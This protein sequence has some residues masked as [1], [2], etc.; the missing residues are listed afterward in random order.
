VFYSLLNQTFKSLSFFCFFNDW[1]SSI[2]GKMFPFKR[3]ISQ[4]LALNKIH[5][6]IEQNLDKMKSSILSWMNVELCF[7]FLM[8][9]EWSRT[10]QKGNWFTQEWSPQF[11]FDCGT[12]GTQIGMVGTCW[13]SK[14]DDRVSLRMRL[15]FSLNNPEPPWKDHSNQDWNLHEYHPFSTSREAL[16]SKG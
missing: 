13:N 7:Q 4:I 9:G 3:V 6:L 10:I 1:M 12:P 11:C 16:R 2:S 8:D 15:D 5:H 14:M